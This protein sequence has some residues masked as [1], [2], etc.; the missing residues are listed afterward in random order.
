V[1]D[2][3]ARETSLHCVPHGTSAGLVRGGLGREPSVFPESCG[4]EM[5]ARDMSIEIERVDADGD[6][7]DELTFQRIGGQHGPTSEMETTVACERFLSEKTRPRGAGPS[8]QHP[9]S[10]P[11]IRRRTRAPARALP[12]YFFFAARPAVRPP[13]DF[14]A[15]FAGAFLLAAFLA[16]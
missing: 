9:R 15:F 8:R 13:L 7:I 10:Y 12:T 14:A 4:R 3:F 5:D 6:R 16:P 2:L 1:L 11:T